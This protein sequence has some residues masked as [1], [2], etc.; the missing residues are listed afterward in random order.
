MRTSF[1]VLKSIK[2]NARSTANSVVSYQRQDLTKKWLARLSNK[3]KD[4]IS[5]EAVTKV[6]SLIDFYMKPAKTFK[7]VIKRIYLIGH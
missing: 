6:G 5:Q 7:D 3:G 1:N 4:S 2:S